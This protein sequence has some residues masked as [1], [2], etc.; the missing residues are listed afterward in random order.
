MDPRLE[1]AKY[2]A[3]FFS[4]VIP[5]RARTVLDVGCGR[6]DVAAHLVARGYKV[7]G[8]D[9]SSAAV[10]QCKRRG[11]HAIETDFAGYDST[12]RYDALLLSR[13]L[14]HM[15]DPRGMLHKAG[16]MLAPGGLVVIEDFA[17]EEVDETAARWLLTMLR[18]VNA[19]GLAAKQRERLPGQNRAA[20]PWWRGIHRHKIHD[21]QTVIAAARSSLAVTQIERVPYLFRYLAPELKKSARSAA[22]LQHA[23]ALELA[24]FGGPKRPFIGI[25]AICRPRFRS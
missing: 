8:I 18:L 13:S 21:G 25:R 7:T 16:R 4:T 24:T 22:M 11:I 14:H 23:H 6:G 2:T 17:I 3:D 12:R 5:R 9:P 19:V 1:A 15:N 20:L 10:N